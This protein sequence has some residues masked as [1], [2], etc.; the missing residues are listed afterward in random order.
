M[1]SGDYDALLKFLADIAVSYPHL[2]EIV[3]AKRAQFGDTAF[4]ETVRRI[5]L[6]VTDTLWVEHLE[7]ME[8]TRSSV[9]LRAYG[10]REPLIEYK[11][12]GLRLFKEMEAHFK[13]QVVSLISTM[14]IEEGQQTQVS[15]EKPAL[16]LNGA[17]ENSSSPHASKEGPKIGRNDPCPC[18]SGKKYKNCHGLNQ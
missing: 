5:A 6:Y 11:K 14:N 7:T 9:N 13:E 16:I 1:L 8:Y 4:F 17:E 10:Q 12:E 15:E 3:E 18:G 2:S